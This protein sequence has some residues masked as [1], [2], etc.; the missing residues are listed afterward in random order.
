MTAKDDDLVKL[1]TDREQMA[2]AT[3]LCLLAADR[4]AE[5]EAALAEAQK[6]MT[7]LNW[8]QAH[9]ELEVR[10]HKHKWLCSGFTNYPIDKFATLREAIDA[11]M[12]ELK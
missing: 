4:I 7:R 6:D 9:P 3:T 11:A 12:Q 8:V 10:T 1:L 5:L 2:H